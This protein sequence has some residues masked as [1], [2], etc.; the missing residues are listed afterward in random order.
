MITRPLNLAGYLR[1]TPRN[2]DVLFVVNAGLLALF[3]T[4]FGSR[5]V[6]SPGLAVDFEVPTMKGVASRPASGSRVVPITV[7]RAGV[8]HVNEGMLKN[9]SDL[10]LWLKI[11]SER[12]PGEKL[13]PSLH[14]LATASVPLSDLVQVMSEARRAG[15][16]EI[17][18][19]MGDSEPATNKK[20]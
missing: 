1:P 19:D 20:R 6:L 12:K 16:Q 7:D 5:F 11:Q 18:L 4:L 17:S 2:F 15:F 9:E 10:R 3:F 14:V 8:K 13:P